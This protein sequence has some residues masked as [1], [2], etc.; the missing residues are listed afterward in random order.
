MMADP[1]RIDPFSQALSDFEAEFGAMAVDGAGPEPG[2]APAMALDSMAGRQ[3]SPNAFAGGAPN[4]MVA[5]SPNP[6]SG[7]G[8]A[9]MRQNNPLGAGS[10]VGMNAAT[11]GVWPYAA[12]GLRQMTGNDDGKD[13]GTLRREEQMRVEGARNTLGD[14]GSTGVELMAP[15]AGI[16]ALMRATGNARQLAGRGAAAGGIYGATRGYLDPIEPDG[17]DVASRLPPA[18]MG[19]AIGTAGGAAGGYAAGRTADKM[20]GWHTPTGGGPGAPPAPQPNAA[21]P[22]IATPPA[23]SAPQS[24]KPTGPDVASIERGRRALMRPRAAVGPAPSEANRITHIASLYG[25]GRDLFAIARDLG[26]P[27]EMIA[28]TIVRSKEISMPRGEKLGA[29]AI[30]KDAADLLADIDAYRGAH[31]PRPRQSRAGGGQ[32]AQPAAPADRSREPL[33]LREPP[34]RTVAVPDDI[35]TTPSA[36]SAPPRDAAKPARGKRVRGGASSEIARRVDAMTE[37]QRDIGRREFQ[38]MQSERGA[39]LGRWEDISNADILRGLKRW[40]ETG[41]KAPAKTPASSAAPNS[42]R[43]AG[44]YGEKLKLTTRKKSFY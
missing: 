16:G 13:Y 39:P 22:A 17:L 5:Y 25:Q 30:Q 21:R 43:G 28:R 6:D 37:Q 8:T 18:L 29:T 38:A 32:G 9:V 11:A 31:P 1:N 36:P 20:R 26:E 33:T 24:P 35:P 19:A 44:R 10:L 14:I 3:A 2:I 23:P 15:M 7:P 34:Q 27:A 12:A 4:P 40:G 41:L 42:D